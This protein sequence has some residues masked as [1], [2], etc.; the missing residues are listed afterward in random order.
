MYPACEIYYYLQ[1]I[2]VRVLYPGTR[3]T[4]TRE[5][6]ILAYAFT[7]YVHVLTMHE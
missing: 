2:Q 6:Q 1:Y 7:I 4:S 5:I 3:T